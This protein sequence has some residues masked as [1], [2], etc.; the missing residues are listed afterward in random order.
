[1]TP[2]EHKKLVV[3]Q[4]ELKEA[5][6]LN[7]KRQQETDT[8][9][10]NLADQLAKV[11][12]DLAKPV[13]IIISEHAILRYLERVQGMDMVELRE[14]IKEEFGLG[15]I[16]VKDGEYKLNVN[17]WR[18]VLKENTLVTIEPMRGKSL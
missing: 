4:Q 8:L 10:T 17:G 9:I 3:K 16:A 12:S 11:E 13:D 7:R 5:I 1:M 18:L 14:T 2:A 6:K 15:A